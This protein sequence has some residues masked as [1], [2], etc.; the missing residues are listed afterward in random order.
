[1]LS[2]A[3]KAAKAASVILMDNF[4]KI[5]SR[6][7]VEKG[8]NDFLTF[9][10]EASEQKIIEI[11]HEVHPNHAIL[12]EESGLN[13][14]ISDFE[15]IIDPL[16]GTKNYITG[17]P[18]FA[19]SI[20]LRIKGSLELGVVIDPVR[21]DLFHAQRGKGAYLNDHKV[22]VTQRSDMSECLIATGFPFKKKQFLSDYLACFND[23]FT[24]SSGARRMGAAAID[25]AYIAAGKFDA[26]WEIGLSPWDIAAG[27]LLIEEAGG[28]LSDFWG[29]NQYLESGHIVASNGLIHNHLQKTIQNHFPEMLNT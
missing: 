5:D 29:N 9:V 24:Q 21:N 28:K 14:K 12:A 17:I 6:D 11:I 18:L 20:A 19:I 3:I 25:L 23:I 2:L 13:K 4:G 10:D 15:W 26:F 8:K 16:D 22:Q 7:I 1:M 27:S